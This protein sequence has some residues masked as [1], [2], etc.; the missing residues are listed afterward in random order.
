LI[1]LAYYKSIL[2]KGQ[3]LSERNPI[4]V[5]GIILDEF[6]RDNESLEEEREAKKYISEAT[7]KVFPNRYIKPKYK[8]KKERNGKVII[9]GQREKNIKIY[10]TE[11]EKTLKENNLT[12]AV[13]IILLC[14]QEH[15][16]FSS[17]LIT[18]IIEK[19]LKEINFVIRRAVS[20]SVRQVIGHMNKNEISQYI[21]KKENYGSKTNNYKPPEYRIKPEYLDT[22]TIEQAYALYSSKQTKLEIKKQQVAQP[23]SQEKIESMIET[24]QPMAV[25]ESDKLLGKISDMIKSAG[26]ITLTGDIHIHINVSK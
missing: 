21:D 12:K 22:F 24:A 18:S 26:G 9:L 15:E 19:K 7:E 17:K 23:I 13:I 14:N 10:E 2:S 3:A 4:T 11:L 8:D 16:W 20:S 1:N 6:L 25:A 5:N